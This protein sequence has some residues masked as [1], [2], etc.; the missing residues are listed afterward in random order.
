M[1]IWVKFA[2]LGSSEHCCVT[3]AQEVRVMASLDIDKSCKFA[4]GAIA[5]HGPRDIG[6]YAFSFGYHN[7]QTTLGVAGAM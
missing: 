1:S 3:V 4:P 5:R 6:S 7:K 2:A